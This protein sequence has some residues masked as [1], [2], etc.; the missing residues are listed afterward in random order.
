[1]TINHFLFGRL[2][3]AMVTPFFPDG[4]VNYDQ[5]VRIA[6]HLIET[7]TDAILLTGTT[8]ESPTLTH[9]EEFKLYQT[10]KKSC[11]KKTKII[12]GTGSNSTTTAVESTQ[13]AEKIGVDGILQVV[14][15]YN[16]PSQ[17]GIYRHFKTV[18]ENTSLPIMLYNIPGRTGVNME[19]ETVARLAEIPNITSI[20]EAAGSV[21]QVKKLYRLV[22]K[23]FIIYSGD[24]GKTLDFMKEGAV[25]VVSVASHIAGL[26]IKEM[27]EAYLSNQVKK[28]EALEKELHP[29]FEVLFIAP[30]P[31]P[32][33]AA[34][35]M[36][37]LNAGPL[38]LPLIEATDTEKAKIKLVLEKIK[39]P[40][41]A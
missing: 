27:I 14:P 21:E 17:E 34:L 26:R 7:G 35:A 9:D 32:L 5:A 20:K 38:R 10:I 28:A 24:D 2:V 41:S 8:G 39:I 12:A 29:L 11:G 25:G 1:M 19:P 33:K 3:T 31:T 23:D 13:E 6:N 36:I 18:A 40:I 30:N 16:K 4:T 37:G 22:P 15:Y